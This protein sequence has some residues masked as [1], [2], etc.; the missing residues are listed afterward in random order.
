MNGSR[1]ASALLAA[2]LLAATADAEP[3]VTDPE[4]CGRVQHLIVETKLE[5]ENVVHPDYQAYRESKTSVQPITNHQF[6]MMEPGTTD[7]P[8]RVSCKIKTPD[9]LNEVYG[10]GS[11]IDTGRTC[12]DVNRDTVRRVYANFTPAE[13][14]AIKLPGD[15][16]WL[17]PDELVMTGGSYVTEY[18][19]AWSTPDGAVHL[20]SKTLRVNWDD[21]RFAWAPDRLRGAMYCHLI[22]PEYVRRIALGEST[23]P[24]RPE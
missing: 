20:Q 12:R 24:P 7:K 22:T 13:R 5:T 18:P 15:Q 21:W 16:I 19:F 14:A 1:A 9:H 8:W 17:E 6:V 11:A 23:V 4:F 2:V 10:E 3:V